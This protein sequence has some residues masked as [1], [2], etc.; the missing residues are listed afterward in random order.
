MDIHT[1]SK[2]S[3]DKLEEILDSIAPK[4][5]KKHVQLQVIRNFFPPQYV[6]EHLGFNF[7]GT[8]YFISHR[9]SAK[10]ILIPKKELKMP[11]KSD[12]PEYLRKCYRK[13]TVV[14]KTNLYITLDFLNDKLR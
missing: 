4:P 10:S 8:W 12:K 14:R 3:I 2:H 9:S 1:C 7:K 5:K 11:I 6:L 13:P